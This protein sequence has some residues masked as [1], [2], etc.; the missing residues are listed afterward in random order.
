MKFS[1][2]TSQCCV[3]A[4]IVGLYHS[5]N[6]LLEDLPTVRSSHF[7]QGGASEQKSA[8]D[9]E[10]GL[11]SDPR[12]FQSRPRRVLSEDGRTLLNLWFIP[13]FSEVLLMFRAL[14]EAA[15]QR[16]LNQTLE[17][18]SALHDIIY[19]LVSFA[20]LGN[21]PTASH[22]R[23]GQRLTAD[24]GGTEGIGAELWDI[25]RQIDSLDDP[26]SPEAVG[27]LLRLRREV[28]FLQ[29][30]AAVRQ[31]IRES[32]LS[33]G[34]CAAYQTVTD[35]MGHALP[36][37]SDSVGG[38]VY[39]SQ[40]PLPQ[41]L[42]PHSPQAQRLFP[43]R[44]FLGQ[45][46]TFPLA[47]CDT[48]PIEY[49][50]QLCF[51]GLRDR[52]RMVANGEILGVSLLTEDILNCGRDAAP[53]RLHVAGDNDPQQGDEAE[54]VSETES[55]GGVEG[56]AFLSAPHRDPL[57]MYSVLRAFLLL[58]KQ[59]E[60][61]RDSWG[62]RQLGVEQINT[63][64]LYK[65][66]SRLYRAEILYPS[67]RA[68]ARKLG[69]EDEYGSPLTDTQPV[70][71]PTGA[72]EVD[73]KTQQLHRLLQCTESDMI[74][75]VQR[76]IARELNLV[77]S[78]RARQDT[79]LPTELWKRGPVQHIFSPE[80]PLILE[81]FIQQLM[82]GG[83]QAEGK[84][85][86]SQ[87]HLRACLTALGCAV[88]GRERSCFQAYS[89]FYEHILQQEGHLLYQREQDVKALEASQRQ[90]H[91]A[92][93]QSQV[94]E[95]CRGMMAEITALRSR[96][97]HMEEDQTALQ[98]QLSTQYQ[99]RYEA[100]IRHL[101][102]TCVQLKRR[103]DEYHVR[104]D[105]DVGQLVGRVRREA[106][107]SMEKLKKRFGSTKDED[108]RATLS[109]HTDLQAL[110]EENSQLV[111]LICKMRA[112]SQWKKS[113]SEG[114]LR[115]QLHQ[116]R[117]EALLLQ[118]ESVTVQTA[119]EEEVRI[120]QQEL[121]A[122]RRA[123]EQCQ[124]EYN[125]TRT[126]LQKQGQQLQ[127][128]EHRQAQE[129]RSRQQ[130]DGLRAQTLQCLQEDVSSREKQLRSLSAQMEQSSRDSRLQRLRSQQELR[131]VRSQLL[132]ERSLKQDAFQRVDELQSQVYE[133]EAVLFRGSPAPGGNRKCQSVASSRRA[134]SGLLSGLFS[135]LLRF[136]Q[137]L[138]LP[139]LWL[140]RRQIQ[141]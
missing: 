10:L 26:T 139:A 122:V 104:M 99:Q 67:M 56:A 13:H 108:L 77:I 132:Q 32:F 6:T 138:P 19:Y 71:P 82:E 20:R 89:L 133:A 24:W 73:I 97:A 62:R 31:R 121:E 96:V 4:Q 2:R 35:N 81:N 29:F 48:L 110:R 105:R 75:A 72:S 76:R 53:F 119:S 135:G 118:K 106:V 78:E 38:S 126:L 61:F 16:A 59:L 113:T 90:D 123:L 49:C 129:E 68:V 39:S 70:T 55:G 3:R 64:A 46:G 134:L 115:S 44:C 9:S 14:E 131:R 66:F 18:A 57:Q 33:S 98:Q 60:V 79:G 34:D 130:L 40:L 42:E 63:P 93:N 36:L 125:S 85:T 111:G 37:L 17:I 43:W 92:D 86:F 141:I 136:S 22:S 91:G 124:E 100:L 69:R 84:V 21:S 117:Q 8:R 101:F 107:A 51:S 30:D 47:I 137:S 50:M 27:R 5:L 112:L 28:L 65:R 87:A 7:M 25:Q 12:S 127:E 109:K 23:T 58:W 103:Q 54:G 95:L 45:H 74:I 1:A 102:S 83:E 88:M 116:C 128:A 52:S 140:R 94:A 120:L 80:R 41:P 15:C 114:K 11:R